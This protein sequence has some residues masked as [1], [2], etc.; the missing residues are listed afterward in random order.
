MKYLIWGAGFRG[1]RYSWHFRAG[2]LIAFVDNDPAKIGGTYQ[3]VPVISFAEY[4]EKYANYFLIIGM[5]SEVEPIKTLEGLGIKKYLLFSECPAE[6][7]VY[8]KQSY[9]WDYLRT[10]IDKKRKYLIYGCSF[11]A[12]QLSELIYEMTGEYA[13][14][15]P[16]KH[17]RT[18]RFE[19]FK[20]TVSESIPVVEHIADV[21][22]DCILA[23]CEDELDWLKEIANGCQV[24]NVFDCSDRIEAYHHPEIEQYKNKHQGQ[25]CFV[26]GNGPSLRIEDLELISANGIPTFAVNSIWRIFDKTEWRPTYYFAEDPGIFSDECP[27]KAFFAQPNK[28][29]EMMFFGDG[30][31]T[32]WKENKPIGEYM[33]FHSHFEFSEFRYPKFSEDLSRRSYEGGTVAY[34]CLQMAV[35]MGFKNIFLLGM[36]R[37][38]PS[39]GRSAVYEHMY[40]D[41]K[42]YYASQIYE[43]GVR[44]GNES[45]KRYADE[46][47]IGI[48]NATRGGYLEIY[49]RVNIDSLFLNEK[50]MW[51]PS[52][53]LE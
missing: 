19:A 26:I 44:L 20:E 18:D 50:F 4:Q 6:Y 38:D 27:D 15:M 30:A 45:A 34:S 39:K 9:L 47:S 53:D 25:S 3:G 14:I 16:S 31:D 41:G 17:F 22:V 8:Y 12:I 10:V 5:L 2:E 28:G 52:D 46:H 36:D 21:N 35:Y 33:I 48:F 37:V 1:A 13:P 11:Y 23:V 42:Q 24:L 51:D 43:E 40:D 29:I 7:H 49:E 32:Y